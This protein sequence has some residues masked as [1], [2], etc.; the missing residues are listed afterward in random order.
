MPIINS[1]ELYNQWIIHIN[2][3]DSYTQTGGTDIILDTEVPEL[4]LSAE[5]NN[6][7]NGTSDLQNLIDLI[8]NSNKSLNDIYTKIDIFKQNSDHL[9]NKT[10]E[11]TDLNNKNQLT[12]TELAMV[13]AELIKTITTQNLLLSKI[14]TY[15][16]DIPSSSQAVGDGDGAGAGAGAGIWS[17]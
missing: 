3:N 9:T 16:N 5:V 13:K 15:I 11:L 2:K 14:D 8:I 6:L 12:E 4:K 17:Q 7:F 10:K 1:N